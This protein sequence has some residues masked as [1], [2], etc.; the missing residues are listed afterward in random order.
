M[1]AAVA[2]ERAQFSPRCDGVRKPRQRDRVTRR[3]QRRADVCENPRVLAR[4]SPYRCSGKRI[5]RRRLR[6]E[7]PRRPAIYPELEEH[8]AFRQGDASGVFGGRSCGTPERTLN[9]AHG[10][11]EMSLSTEADDQ[12]PQRVYSALGGSGLPDSGQQTIGDSEVPGSNLDLG[13]LDRGF[14]LP[15]A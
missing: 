3:S 6:R 10:L 1:K 9:D 13:M 2:L 15:I 5:A 12:I 14:L 4:N 8:L 11:A 7:C